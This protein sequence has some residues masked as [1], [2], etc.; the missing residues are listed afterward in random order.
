MAWV[1][2][3]MDGSPQT[4]L[5]AQGKAAEMEPPQILYVYRE[6]WKPGTQA[7]LNRIEREG[8]RMCIERGC[9]H[10]YLGIESVTG[11]KEVWYLNGFASAEEKDRVQEE[12]TRKG[13][14]EAMGRFTE[15][16]APYQ[17]G[18]GKDGL[19]NYRPALSRGAP[20][21]MGQ[22]RYLVIQATRRNPQCDGTVFEADDGARLTVM[23]AQT[24]AEAE[25]KVKAFGAGARI[26][27][28]RP[29]FSMPSTDWV[30]ADPSFW[31]PST[32]QP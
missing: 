32:R 20:W 13:L 26:F 31:A 2:A 27:A 1:M 15:Q 28:V 5:Q 11:P 8:A 18:P 24:R 12:Y 19:S 3:M 16:R 23:P 9:P 4:V 6:F 14:Y 29:E 17:A 21:S 10:P 30:T 22:G 25:A 7:A